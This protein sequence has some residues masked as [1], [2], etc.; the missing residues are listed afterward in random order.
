MAAQLE[1]QPD[2]ER[3]GA[4]QELVIG[5]TA[6]LRDFL[7]DNPEV[8]AELREL[9]DRVRVGLP[10]TS[11]VAG[12]SVHARDHAVQYVSQHGNVYVNHHAPQEPR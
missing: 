5:W 8:A 7:E 9:I 12:Q 2:H 3:E 6:R 1:Q 11:N 4:R 10:E